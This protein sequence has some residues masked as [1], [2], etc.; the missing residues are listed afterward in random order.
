[1][2]EL[3]QYADSLGWEINHTH[4]GH[5]RFTRKGSPPVFTSSSPGDYRSVKNVRAMLRRLSRQI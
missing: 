1:M 2:Q 4:G 5:I 3:M